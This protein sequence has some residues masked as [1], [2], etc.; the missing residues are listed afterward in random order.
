[1]CYR[2]GMRTIVCMSEVPCGDKMVESLYF[3]YLY[4]GSKLQHHTYSIDNTYSF[5]SSGT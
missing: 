4:V 1:V 2:D 3:N 5:S